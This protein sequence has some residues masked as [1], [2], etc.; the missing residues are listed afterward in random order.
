MAKKEIQEVQITEEK[1]KSVF[2]C[3]EYTNLSFVVKTSSMD[4]I[5]GKQVFHSGKEVK[6]QNGF[7]VTND[8]EAIEKIRAHEWYGLKITEQG[9]DHTRVQY[10]IIGEEE[11]LEGGDAGESNA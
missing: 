6:F 10:G 9:I 5:N 2:A 1:Q 8:Q 7:L 3:P 11:N 4:T